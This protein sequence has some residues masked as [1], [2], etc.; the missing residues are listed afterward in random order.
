MSNAQRF[1]IPSTLD[2]PE[3]MAFWTVDEFVILIGCM[4]LGIVFGRFVEGI[5]AGFLGVHLIKRFKKGE[6]LNVLRH[7]LYWYAPS[8][9]FA[10][11]AT[12]ASHKRQLAG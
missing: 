1:H 8:G 12:L 2:E 10:F 3:K 6:S 11:K 5:I 4:G 7:A 9:L